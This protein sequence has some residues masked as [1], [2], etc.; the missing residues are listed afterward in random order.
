LRVGR[1]AVDIT[2]PSGTPML[3]PQRPP[4]EIKLATRPHDPLHAKAV[5]LDQ[6]DTRVALVL[7]DLTSIPLSVIDQTRELIGKNTKVPA[8]AAM[9]SATH[10]HTT[11]QI[12]LKFIGNANQAAKEKARAYLAALPGKIAEAVRLAEADL[13]TAHASAVI[14]E[15]DSVSF[16]RR[17][18]LRDGAVQA[19][20]FK[21]EDEKLRDDAWVRWKKILKG[22]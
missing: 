22:L 15:E 9:I 21:G 1:A 16:N 12:R 2:P 17:F 8:V 18:F 7:C 3:T 13:Q 5:V 10:T 6:G 19:N 4:F 20:P 14:G 11:P